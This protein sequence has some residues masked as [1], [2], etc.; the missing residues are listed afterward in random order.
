MVYMAG[1]GLGPEI[2]MINLDYHLTY[3]LDYRPDRGQG[4]SQLY[5]PTSCLSDCLRCQSQVEQEL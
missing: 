5:L 3:F 4:E 1:T 2:D